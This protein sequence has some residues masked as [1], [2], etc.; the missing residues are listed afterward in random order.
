M[1]KS[2][3]LLFGLAILAKPTFTN[4]QTAAIVGSTFQIANSSGTLTLGPANTDYCHMQTDRTK[5]WFNK[6][7]Y[8]ESLGGPSVVAYNT[9]DFIIA[10]NGTYAGSTSRM[11]ISASTGFVGMGIL[12]PKTQLQI[13]GSLTLNTTVGQTWVMESNLYSGGSKLMLGYDDASGTYHYPLMIDR[14]GNIGIGIQSGAMDPGSLLS[15]N[16]KIRA[17]E[18]RVETTW[19][20][21]VFEKKYNLPS[22]ATVADFISKNGHL[23]EIPSASDVECNGI[24]LGQMDA[25]LLQK[26]EELTLYM[27]EL[28][29][30]N[31]ALKIAVEKLQT[32]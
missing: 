2:L 31:D 22:L 21:F 19:S 8:I 6:P 15:V 23:P 18:I 32:K 4:G 7:L 25:K 24:E 27:I 11:T 29:K 28:K 17:K 13:R 5:F 20:D 16:G 14:T 30:Q 1:K 10:T 9:N 3:V 12:V 26:I